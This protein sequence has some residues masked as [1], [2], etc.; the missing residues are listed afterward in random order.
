MRWEHL[1]DDL[2]GQWQQELEA[3]QRE[4]ETEEERLRVARLGIRERLRF[5]ARMHEGGSV[6]VALA[7]GETITLVVRSIGRDWCAADL[8]GQA[9][10]MQCIL[11]LDAI[12]A[13]LLDRVDLEAS[14]TPAPTD[15]MAD[16]IADK[17]GIGV[18]LR[19]LARRRTFTDISTVDG[20]YSGTIDRIGRDHI[21]LAIHDED[22][23]RRERAVREFRILPISRITLIRL[24]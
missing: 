22:E 8:V 6:R 21:D 20:M 9:R 23:T 24:R 18:V 4:L 13:V 11:P 5:L 3:E 1:F 16:R 12:A 7:T 2:S 17:T 19:D 10:A 14:L 15:S